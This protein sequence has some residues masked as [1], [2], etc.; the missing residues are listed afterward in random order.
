MRVEVGDLSGKG[1]LSVTLYKDD[2]VLPMFQ[3]FID[4]RYISEFDKLFCLRVS[5]YRRLILL[6]SRNITY[7]TLLFINS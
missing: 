2:L 5:K 1:V 6:S 3:V 4:A 7:S